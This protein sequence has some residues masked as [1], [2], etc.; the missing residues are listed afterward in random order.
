[1]GL[2]SPFNFMAKSWKGQLQ[3][4]S[5]DGGNLAIM[6]NPQSYEEGGNDSKQCFEISYRGHPLQSIAWQ[7]WL[8]D[9]LKTFFFGDH[10]FRVLIA[11]QRWQMTPNKKIVGLIIRSTDL[12]H[13][14]E[15]LLVELTKRYIHKHTITQTQKHTDLKRY[16]HT[17]KDN[18]LLESQGLIISSYYRAHKREGHIYLIFVFIPTWQTK[19]LQMGLAPFTYTVKLWKVCGYWP[20]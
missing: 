11:S 7:R 9:F 19:L 12:A 3:D 6:Q 13:I 2:I 17:N 5:I 4:L 16:K 18:Q 8:N 10:I 14:R 1:M 15:S 20:S